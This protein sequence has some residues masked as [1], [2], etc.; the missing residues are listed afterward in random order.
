MQLAF[1]A[2]K[3]VGNAIRRAKAK[4]K[5]RSLVLENENRLK[6]GNYIFVA[7]DSLLEKEYSLL[8]KDFNF[9][10]NKSGLFL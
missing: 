9:A 8:I 3:K 6:K 5:L 10:M 4:R 1:I 2:S 7:K